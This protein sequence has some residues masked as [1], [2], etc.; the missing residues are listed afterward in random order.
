[1]IKTVWLRTLAVP[2]A[3]A[4]FANRVGRRKGE[5]KSALSFSSFIC[6]AAVKKSSSGLQQVHL[7]RYLREDLPARSDWDSSI[8]V[9]DFTARGGEGFG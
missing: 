1:M 3:V 4:P 6:I 5:D 8:F 9:P 2:A 7:L